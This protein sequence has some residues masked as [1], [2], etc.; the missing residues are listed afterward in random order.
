MEVEDIFN[1]PEKLVINGKEYDFEFDNRAFATLEGLTQKGTYKIR[2]LLLDNNLTLNECTE[3]VCCGLIKN[4][5]ADEISVI[6]QELQKS[7][8]VWTSNN[9][10]ILKA[11]LK[12]LMPPEI[13][14]KMEEV[15]AKLQ[16]LVDKP[17][18]KKKPKK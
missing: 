14:L 11:F 1:I 6:R 12:P 2:E 9:D 7:P 4:Y 13:Y 15:K 8:S 16:K 17:E 5:K 18:K 10:A 3:L